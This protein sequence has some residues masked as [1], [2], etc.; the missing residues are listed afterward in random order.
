MKRRIFMT[1]AAAVTAAVPAFAGMAEDDAAIRQIWVDYQTARVAGDGEK[2]LG[3]WDDDGI[4]MPPGR[5]P[6]TKAELDEIIPTVFKPGIVSMMEI[7]PEEIVVSGDIAYSLGTYASDR[8]N[9]EGKEIHLEGKFMTILKRQDDDSWK[10]YR[11]IF[12]ANPQ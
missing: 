5:M 11:D 8:L 6:S 4:Q 12:N 1:V 2:W 3:L 7:N 9:A 10:I